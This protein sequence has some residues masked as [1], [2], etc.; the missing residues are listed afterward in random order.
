MKVN[1][2]AIISATLFVGVQAF[3]TKELQNRDLI[4]SLGNMVKSVVDGH[5]S[6]KT[7]TSKAGIG[8]AFEKI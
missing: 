7:N 1:W 8:Q 3:P 5:E 2:A 4:E 6:N